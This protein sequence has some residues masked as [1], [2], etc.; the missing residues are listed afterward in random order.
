MR[1]R[2]AFSNVFSVFFNGAVAERKT[3]RPDS[4]TKISDPGDRERRGRKEK[5]VGKTTRIEFLGTTVEESKNGLSEAVITHNAPPWAR[6]SDA[7]HYLIA[8]AHAP[9]PR[10]DLF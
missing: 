3:V 5:T 8:A 2:S 1:V 7:S 4:P 9:P 6:Y 10:H